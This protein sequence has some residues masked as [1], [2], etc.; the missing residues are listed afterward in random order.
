M[1]RT[2]DK[3]KALALRKEGKSYSEIKAVLGISKSTL[4]GWL[5]DYP[6]SPERIKELRDFSPRRIE[7]YR[8]TMRVK[9]EKRSDEVYSLV[10]K[11]IGKI[12]DREALIGGMFLY[13][14]EGGKTAR[15]TVA[16][17]NTDPA[18]LKFYIHWL[19]LLGIQK[20]DLR[21]KLQIYADMDIEESIKFWSRELNLPI[22]SFTKPYVKKSNLSDLTYKNGFGYGT[23]VIKYYDQKS[24][25]YVMMA[26]KYLKDIYCE[27]S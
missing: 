10:K 4:S 15:S 19:S 18:M 22:D 11:N 1:A 23:C 26:L 16:L 24:S 9:R 3:Q 17:S 5:E 20:K 12:S 21:V 27:R 2:Q 14:G 25:D 6:L 13:W 8:N 7:S